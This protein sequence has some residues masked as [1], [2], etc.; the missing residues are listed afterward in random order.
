M[1]LTFIAASLFESAE[2]KTTNRS[3]LE[4]LEFPKIEGQPATSGHRQR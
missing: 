2:P 1:S 4:R 3:G